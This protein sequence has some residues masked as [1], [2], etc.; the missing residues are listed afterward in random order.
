MTKSRPQGQSAGRARHV[1]Q[2]TCVACREVDSKRGLTRLVRIGDDR[3]AIDPSGK[4][5][6]RGAY[7]CRRSS[8]WELALKRQS[9]QRALRV[10]ALHPDDSADLARFGAAFGPEQ[11][12]E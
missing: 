4:R 3:V 1:P 2:R 12:V 5:A 11:P 8:C 10:A 7:L 9:L 6:G